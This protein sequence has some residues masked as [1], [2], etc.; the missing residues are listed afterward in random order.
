MTTKIAPLTAGVPDRLV[1]LPGGVVE[2][3]EL[4]STA[5]SLRPI[6]RVWHA[7]AAQ[8]GTT[9]TVL[10]GR[11]QVEAWAAGHRARIT[12]AANR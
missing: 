3:V 12:A 1:L 7:R 5:G 11:E 2:L 4:K 6:Q 10:T 9:V 8:T